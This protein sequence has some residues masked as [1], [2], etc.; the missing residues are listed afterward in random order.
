[1]AGCGVWGGFGADVGWFGCGFV[2]FVAGMMVVCLVMS[3]VVL[4]W[5]DVGWRVLGVDLL[6]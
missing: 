4:C 6:W 1:M 3:F 5:S 2:G